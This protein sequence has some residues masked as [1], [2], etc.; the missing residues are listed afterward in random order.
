VRSV[1]TLSKQHTNVVLRLEQATLADR[2][3]LTL[4]AI[5]ELLDDYLIDGRHE[6]YIALHHGWLCWSNDHELLVKIRV[7]DER[8]LVYHHRGLGVTVHVVLSGCL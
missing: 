8:V 2:A 4:G 1:L 3:K 5:L 6:D 7:V